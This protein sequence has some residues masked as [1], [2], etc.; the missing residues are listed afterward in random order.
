MRRIL[1]LALALSLS[2]PACVVAGGYSSDRGFY[3]WPGSILTIVVIIAVLFL[4]RRRR[5]R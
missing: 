2:Q 4:I 1:L 5:G 3:I